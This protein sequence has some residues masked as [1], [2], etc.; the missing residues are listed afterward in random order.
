MYS[1]T[2][3]HLVDCCLTSSVTTAYSHPLLLLSMY[4]PPQHLSWT[5]S[6][7]RLTLQSDSLLYST[8]STLVGSS[9]SD[10]LAVPSGMP[11]GAVLG[12][13]RFSLFINDLPKAITGATTRLSADDT[14]I[15]A[16]GKDVASIAES[17]T[18]ALHIAAE[19]LCDNHLNLNVQKTKPCSFALHG[20]QI[21]LLCPF[22]SFPHQLSNS[23]P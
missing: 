16:V 18:S 2:A 9:V 4:L 7:P 3:I 13:T 10:P 19:W 11:Q 1:Q 20:E 5:C 12:P 22:T 17:L 15:Y 8:Q 6:S 21:C 23:T 14:T